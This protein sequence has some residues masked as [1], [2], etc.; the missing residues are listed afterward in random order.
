MSASAATLDR[1]RESGHLKL[2]YLADA[3]PLSFRT[4]SGADGYGVALCQRVADELKSQ[5]GLGG[6]TVD[7]VPVEPGNLLGDVQ[8]GNID[9]LCVPASV[10]LERRQ[11]VSFSIPVYPGGIRAAVRADA[12]A[13]LREALGDTPTGRPVWRGSP[14]AKVLSGSSFGA[15]SGT[16]AEGWL[17]ERLKTFQMD[18]KAVGVPDYKAG[19]QQLLDRKVNVLFGDPSVI[20]AATDPASRDKLTILD[21]RF[22]HEPFAL[23]LARNDDDFRL[24]VDGA[25]SKLYRSSDLQPLYRKWFGEFDEGTRLFFLWNTPP[26]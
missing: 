3:R 19:V 24:L 11:Q 7:W 17:A 12:P 6:L 22:T 4:E 10:T 23:A 18:A 9:L 13:E 21:R 1:V 2:G 26:Q 15:V 20:L 25:L 14:A 16:T 5:T 8:Q